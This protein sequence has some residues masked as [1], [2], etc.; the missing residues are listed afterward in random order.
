M[1]AFDGKVVLVTGGASGIGFAT[2][3]RLLQ[4]GAAIIVWD[5]LEADIE[6]AVRRLDPSGERCRGFAVDVASASQ[7]EAAFSESL[8]AFGELHCAFNN[9][10]IGVPTV[11][12]ADISEAEFDKVMAVNLKGV[13]LS[14]KYELQHFRSRGGSIVNNASV[15][16]LVALAGQGAYTSAKHGVVGL[17]K[18]AA[19]EYAGAGVRVNAVCPGAIQTPILAHLEA[20]G[21]DEA[22]LAGM[23][24]AARVGAPTEVASAVLWLLSD[25]ASF[26]TGAALSVDGGWAAQ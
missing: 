8:A 9:A 4:S 14:M 12:M 2:C 20:A 17:T 26:V 7:V 3:E 19:V 11:P 16:G 6:N 25:E 1:P 5:K 21:I 13:W 23:S 24:P 22:A 18:T 15:S 10:G